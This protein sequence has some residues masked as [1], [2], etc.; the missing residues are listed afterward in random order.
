MKRILLFAVLLSTSLI[1]AQEQKKDKLIIEKGTWTL[2]G[3]VSFNTDNFESRSDLI[4]RDVD[5]NIIATRSNE[6][7]RDFTSLSLF[8]RI[9]FVFSD[10]WVIGILA[11]YSVA[12]SESERM[13][14]GEDTSNSEFKR[15][16]ISLAPYVRKYFGITR[17]L[18]LYAQGEIGYGRFWVENIFDDQERSTDS[19]DN[20]FVNVRPGIS[21][22]ATKNLALESSIGVLGYSVNTSEGENFESE[23]QSFVFS[24]NSSNLLFGLSYFF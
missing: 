22:F 18:A 6:L 16:N 11:E 7:D 9:G 5:G 3:N 17:N 13:T 4:T 10:N 2:G 8:P 12:N 23:N 20:F 19:G 21:F 14:E 1:Y 15:E 24:I